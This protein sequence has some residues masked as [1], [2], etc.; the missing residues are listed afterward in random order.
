VT[1]S[2]FSFQIDADSSIESS[3]S[4]GDMDSVGEKAVPFPCCIAE[5]EALETSIT[6]LQL[7]Q[8]F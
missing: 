7:S 2:E 5:R 1:D 4:S 3:T 6:R 8:T